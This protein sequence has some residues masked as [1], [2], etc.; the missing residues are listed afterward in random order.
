MYNPSNNVLNQQ[1]YDVYKDDL[2]ND[3][4][5]VNQNT[6][7]ENLLNDRG[8]FDTH[9]RASYTIHGGAMASDSRSNGGTSTQF[10]RLQ[11]PQH[12]VQMRDVVSR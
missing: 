3:R 5:L 4:N 12:N 1:V 2:R 9:S 11:I 10:G 6:N 8:G 7:L